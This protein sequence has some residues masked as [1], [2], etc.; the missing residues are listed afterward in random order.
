MWQLRPIIVIRRIHWAR[1]FDRDG[2]K[3]V[4]TSNAGIFFLLLLLF[5]LIIIIIMFV[6]L[7]QYS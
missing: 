5:P 1:S 3:E 6:I 7:C 2:R 4:F